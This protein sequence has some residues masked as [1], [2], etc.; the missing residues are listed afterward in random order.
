MTPEQRK[1]ADALL[2]ALHEFVKDREHGLPVY[3]P[4]QMA[5]M[6][7]IVEDWLRTTDEAAVVTSGGHP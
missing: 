3:D 5:Q 7:E 2:L 4:G 6:R 1:R